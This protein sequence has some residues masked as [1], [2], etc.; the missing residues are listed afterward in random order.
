VEGRLREGESGRSGRMGRRMCGR[1]RGL[2][3]Y[4]VRRK[5]EIGGGGRE[6]AERREVGD[7]GQREE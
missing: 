2:E 1:I 4:M 3:E 5:V 7:A 6:K